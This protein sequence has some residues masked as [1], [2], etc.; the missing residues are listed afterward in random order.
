MTREADVGK[1]AR[2][3]EWYAPPVLR[4]VLSGGA[5]TLVLLV[6]C[7][8]TVPLTQVTVVFDAEGDL[9]L[10]DELVVTVLSGPGL[11]DERHTQTVGEPRFPLRLALVPLQGDVSRRYEVRAELRNGGLPVAHLLARSGYV[12]GDHRE[13]HLT[14]TQC[15]VDAACGAEQTCRACACTDPDIDPEDLLPVDPPDAGAPGD[16]G[17]AGAVDAPALD[18][19][20]EDA[21]DVD[22]GDVCM[23]PPRP[24]FP[25]NGQRTATREIDFGWDMSCDGTGMVELQVGT[26][27]CMPGRPVRDCDLADSGA[28]SN[29]GRTNRATVP[30]E[31]NGR[32]YWRVRVCVSGECGA[33]SETR[34]VDAQRAT[35]DFDADGRADLALGAPGSE[36]LTGAVF[37][38]PGAEVG[39]CGPDCR[40]TS[41]TQYVARPG[42]ST[43]GR[44]GSHVVCADLDGDGFDELV[45]SEHGNDLGGPDQGAIHIVRGGPEGLD[46]DRHDQ[47]TPT[48][49]GLDSFV[50]AQFGSALASAG[51]VNADG[52]EDLI[53]G[54]TNQSAVLLAGNAGVAAPI[55]LLATFS[56]GDRFGVQVAAAGDV[57]ADGLGDVAIGSSSGAE[58]FLGGALPATDP[59]PLTTGAVPAI[60][61]GDV[62]GDGFDDLVFAVAGMRALALWRPR[63]NADPRE[64][65]TIELVPV[66]RELRPSVAVGTMFPP[67]EAGGTADIV[68]RCVAADGVALLQGNEGDLPTLQAF[69]NA[70]PSAE[71]FGFD[72]AFLELEPDGTMNYVVGAPDIA[73]SSD[74]A[75]RYG[76]AELQ[77]FMGGG[78]RL[79][80]AVGQ[81]F[82]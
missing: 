60:A 74:H 22:A 4:A 72:L 58:I 17:D 13:L 5:L 33:W 38:W 53:V 79:G 61:T 67:G 31:A 11:A 57:D 80:Q 20:T 23:R 70:P 59:I 51:D 64:T 75:F 73:G 82:R 10:S 71:D 40:T 45:F 29:V 21:P 39:A 27:R 34:Y 66:D 24:L 8:D 35:C 25:R 9:R 46:A 63:G 76:T 19:G 28:T 44:A 68:V 14:F 62:D 1:P 15:C 55:R 32:H 2:P 50:G 47:I 65:R 36:S 41:A 69:V 56:G 77:R 30:L 54:A 6:G 7:R 26:E 81:G 16:A 43:D 52:L 78:E 18:A 12:P 48:D 3:S 37:V 49:L 42:G